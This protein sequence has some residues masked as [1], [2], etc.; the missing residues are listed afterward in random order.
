MSTTSG[1]CSGNWATFCTALLA[2][3]AAAGAAC[4]PDPGATGDDQ[5]DDDD[6]NGFIDGG[7]F[8]DG[9]G[10]GGDGG[11]DDPNG[12]ECSNLKLRIR[13]FPETHPDFETFDGDFVYPGLVENQLGADNTPVYAASGPTSQTAGATEF[14]QWYHDSPGVNQPVDVTIALTE[15]TPGLYVYDNSEFFPVDGMG[16]G[17]ESN[18]H[19]FHFTTEIHTRFVYKGGETFTFRGDDDLWLFINGKLAVD[20]GGLHPP[21]EGVVDLDA[22]AS[23]LGITVGNEYAMEIFHAERHTTWSNFHIETTIDCFVVP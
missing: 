10:F 11:I 22:Q 12:N 4:G 5:G 13:D 9:G 2:A 18:P 1:R 3:C 21:L 14:G 15:T 23:A 8:V 20:L 7:G 16:F 19:N 6:P 17:N